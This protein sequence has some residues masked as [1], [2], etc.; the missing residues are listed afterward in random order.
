[1]HRIYDSDNG[2]DGLI[3]S[4]DP[5]VMLPILVYDAFGSVGGQNK[6][7]AIVVMRA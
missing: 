7:G 6:S 4:G 3:E 5:L 1:M 2:V